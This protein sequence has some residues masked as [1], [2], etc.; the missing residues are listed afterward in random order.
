MLAIDQSLSLSLS[1]VI[2]ELL[3]L[4]RTTL[5][6]RL[7]IPNS[8]LGTNIVFRLGFMQFPFFRNLDLVDLRKFKLKVG[9]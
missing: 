7:P 6:M 2:V 8:N 1:V 3:E 5:R 4:G 9:P